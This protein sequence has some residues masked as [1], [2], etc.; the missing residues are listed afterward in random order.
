MSTDKDSEAQLTAVDSSAPQPQAR[1]TPYQRFL[2]VIRGPMAE[3]FGTALLVIFGAGAGAAVV[4]TANPTVSATPKGV[5]VIYVCL[6]V[7][8]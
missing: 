6:R 5:G 4:T 2:H 3:F 8:C 7:W 1:L